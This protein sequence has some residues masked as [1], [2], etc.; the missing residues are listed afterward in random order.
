MLKRLKNI[1]DKNNNNNLR[2]IEGPRVVDVDPRNIFERFRQQLT[3]EGKEIFNQI[4][5]ERRQIN[6]YIQNNFRGGNNQEYNFS[7][8][9]RIGDLFRRI[10]NGETMIPEAE[11]EQDALNDEYD[12]LQ[13]YRPRPNTNYYQFREEF[14]NNARHLKDG[15]RLLTDAFR[16]RIFPLRDPAFYPRFRNGSS[17]SDDGNNGNTGGNDENNGG[18]N[19]HNGN[20]GNNGNNG[21]NNGNN[22][23]N[24]ENDGENNENDDVS[25]KT[26]TKFINVSRKRFD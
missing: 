10:Y 6:D 4:L 1:E 17:D 11:R 26:L 18:N 12:R 5:S 8:F 24:D 14:L 16:N 22:G 15:R 19:V 9:V 3:P 13:R 23:G 21:G 7:N 2:A 20:N 25:D